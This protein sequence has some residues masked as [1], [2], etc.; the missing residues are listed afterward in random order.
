MSRSLNDLAALQNTA[1]SDAGRMARS[2]RQPRRWTR[3]RNCVDRITS[4][5]RLMVLQPKASLLRRSPPFY[6]AIL[7]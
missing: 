7:P 1:R 5:A 6:P 3:V 4:R 2:V